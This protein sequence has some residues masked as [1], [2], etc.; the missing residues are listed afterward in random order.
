M[1]SR[2]L[3]GQVGAQG[4]SVLVP[5]KETSV[6]SL[7]KTST[8]ALAELQVPREQ[9]SEVLEQIYNGS[10]GAIYRTKI[11]TGD[12]AKSKTIVLKAL[13]GKWRSVRLPFPFLLFH[14]E[15]PS[16]NSKC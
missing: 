14:C 3:N 10:C 12:P 2:S 5:L 13:K 11:H 4:E 8:Q 9:L 7:L 15:P 1:P 6:E 16:L